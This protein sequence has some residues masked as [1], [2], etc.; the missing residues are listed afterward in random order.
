MEILDDKR[1][2]SQRVEAK[3]ILK[4]LRNPERYRRF[5]DA[6]FCRMWRGHETA[7]ALYFNAAV[8][9]WEGRGY[10]NVECTLEESSG[11]AAQGTGS[12]RPFRLER[13]PRDRVPVAHSPGGWELDAGSPKERN[14]PPQEGGRRHPAPLA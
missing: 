1:L 9:E 7:L 5:Q 4:W 11:S 13:A 10:S 8:V 3:A 6:G 2:G 14:E 12:L